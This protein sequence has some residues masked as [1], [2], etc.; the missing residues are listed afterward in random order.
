MAE[1][2]VIAPK[3]NTTTPA[4]TAVPAATPT[5]GDPQ[6]E[7]ES[8]TE[9]VSQL[10]E[11]D[12]TPKEVDVDTLIPSE[13][14]Y[15]DPL[16][17]EVANYFGIEQGDYDGAKL[18]L[19]DIVDYII[20]DIKSNQPDQVL[21]ALRKLERQLQPNSWDEK[22]YSNVHKYI[23]LAQKQSTITHAMEAFKK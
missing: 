5:T 17:Y 22:R 10:T 12:N 16:F 1:E 6:V 14:Y 8:K 11:V 21:L 13:P 15:M 18:K 23:R 4:V 7:T 20:R 3:T 19:A 9:Q 2:K